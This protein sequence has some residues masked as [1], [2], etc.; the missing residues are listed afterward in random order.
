MP[1]LGGYYI[2]DCEDLDT[3]LRYAA[4]IPAAKHGSVEVRPAMVMGPL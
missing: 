4:M 3:V 1:G 2:L